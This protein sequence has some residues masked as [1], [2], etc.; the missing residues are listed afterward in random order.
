MKY[1]LPEDITVHS[2][3]G[4][5]LRY[6][7]DTQLFDTADPNDRVFYIKQLGARL[8]SSEFAGVKRWCREQTRL[9]RTRES[10]KSGGRGSAAI[11]PLLP[12]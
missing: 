1:K 9:H 5:P 6:D 7:P 8:R 4:K 11:A 2:E 3:S 12:N 10:V